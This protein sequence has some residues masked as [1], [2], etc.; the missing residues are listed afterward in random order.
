MNVYGFALKNVTLSG[1]TL[2]GPTIE[3]AIKVAKINKMQG[4]LSYIV[5][6]IMT[7]GLINDLSETIELL[8]QATHLPISI[9]IVG[10]GNDDF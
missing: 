8:F 2:F 7:D 3:E 10:I 4:S 6:L 1:P 5:L 9:I